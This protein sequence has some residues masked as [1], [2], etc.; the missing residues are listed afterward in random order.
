VNNLAGPS[1]IDPP[2]AVLTVTSTVHRAQ[3]DGSH[4]E[5][6][7]AVTV[8]AGRFDAAEAP[9]VRA[10]LCRIIDAGATTVLIDLSAVTFIDS[11]GLAA[12]VRGR[13]DAR[14]GG[15]DVILVSPSDDSALRVFRLTQFD[16]VFRMVKL[17]ADA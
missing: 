12:L 13:R 15:G 11:A 5:R 16:D 6:S 14:A 9:L 8:L 3:S 4:P 1:S 17:R 7:S 10:E 2:V